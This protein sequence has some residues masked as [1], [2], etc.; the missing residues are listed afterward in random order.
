MI[1]LFKSL[2]SASF[3]HRGV[4]LGWFP[5]LGNRDAFHFKDT[6]SRIKS[7]NSSPKHLPKRP[8]LLEFSKILPICVINP[9]NSMDT[10]IF[11]SKSEFHRALES[12][13]LQMPVPV[14]CHIWKL[15]SPELSP[16]DLYAWK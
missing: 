15:D 2:R 9:T 7:Y 14:Q 8:S 16:A 12:G 3:D 4:P 6:K 13:Y 10:I 11:K 1:A 5:Q